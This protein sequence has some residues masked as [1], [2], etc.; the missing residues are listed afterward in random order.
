MAPAPSFAPGSLFLQRELRTR[1]DLLQETTEQ[2][3]R[4]KQEE[5]KEW[6]DKSTRERER[7]FE[8][9][10]VVWA[11]NF[12]VWERWIKGKKKQGS[13]LASYIVEL[14]DGRMWRR[15]IV[16]LRRA[17]ERVSKS[18]GSES[19]IEDKQMME[20]AK[21]EEERTALEETAGVQIEQDTP[22]AGEGENET[23][24]ETDENQKSNVTDIL[25]CPD[26]CV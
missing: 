1:L 15:H 6:H 18:G 21:E 14:A 7:G 25:A 19:E 16:H 23:E 8:P 4:K 11:R 22:E 17:E 2:I 9:N 20:S 24:N 26:F 3:V 10:N 13:G 5:Q 12:G